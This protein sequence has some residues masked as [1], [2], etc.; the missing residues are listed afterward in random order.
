MTKTVQDHEAAAARQCGEEG[1]G[2]DGGQVLSAAARLRQGEH[3]QPGEDGQA[4]HGEPEAGPG[5]AH[6]VSNEQDE[7]F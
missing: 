6:Q 1:P 5:R 4:A 7:V 3:R 2:G